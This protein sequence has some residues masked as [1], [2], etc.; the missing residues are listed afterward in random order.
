MVVAMDSLLQCFFHMFFPCHAKMH[1]FTY[2]GSVLTIL[3]VSCLVSYLESELNIA[4]VANPMPRRGS[5]ES[6][7]CSSYGHTQ[8]IAL[9]TYFYS[10]PLAIK[11]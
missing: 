3:E 6:Y 8:K 1:W 7:L 4:D 11:T 9:T 10:Y 2:S 5:L